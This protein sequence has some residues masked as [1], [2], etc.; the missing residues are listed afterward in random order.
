MSRPLRTCSRMKMSCIV[1]AWPRRG[2]L[3]PLSRL[4]ERGKRARGEILRHV[5]CTLRRRDAFR[6]LAWPRHGAE[7]LVDIPLVFHVRSLLGA[8]RVHLHDHLVV[9]G[10]EIAFARLADVE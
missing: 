9:V 10:A 2:L 5:A 8:Y 1:M 7:R 3:F 6:I 4:R